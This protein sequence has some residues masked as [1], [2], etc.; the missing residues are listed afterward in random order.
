MWAI[1]R[2]LDKVGAATTVVTFSHT[3]ELLYSANERAETKYRYSGMGNSTDP[4][5]A[6]MYAKSVL[7]NSNRAIKVLIPIT[8][9][10]WSDAESCNDV[11]R[12]MRTAGVITALGMIGAYTN[13]N[14]QVTIDTHGCEVAVAVDDMSQ[15]FRLAR[16]MVKVGVARNLA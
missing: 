13:M 4:Y 11:I 9:G 2:A 16:D 12:Q 8:D 5:E 15:L 3:T 7:A 14:N 10:W 1:K 6:L